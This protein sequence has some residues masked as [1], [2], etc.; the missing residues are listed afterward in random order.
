MRNFDNFLI[1]ENE[2]VIYLHGQF[3]FTN[4]H[5]SNLIEH[6]KSLDTDI[7]SPLIRNKKKLVY[8][9]GYFSENDIY[10]LDQRILKMEELVP[11]SCL[12]Y[13]RQTQ[14]HYQQLF[15]CRKIFYQQ[16]FDNFKIS[17]KHLPQ[18]RIHATPFIQVCTF[19]NHSQQMIINP[20]TFENRYWSSSLQKHH[21]LLQ[22]YKIENYRTIN[23]NQLPNVLLLIEEEQLDL[24]KTKISYFQ[25]VKANFF[26]F[27]NQPYQALQPNRNDSKLPSDF[28]V[29]QYLLLNRDIKTLPKKHYLRHGRNE[30][31]EY[32]LPN[33]F[34]WKLYIF[35]NKDLEIIRKR[36]QSEEHYLKFGNYDFR[37]YKK[38]ITGG[39]LLKK[40]NSIDCLRY[41]GIHVNSQMINLRE[42]LIRNNNLFDY[43]LIL[44]KDYYNHHLDMISKISSR[45][46]ISWIGDSYHLVDSYSR[47]T[48]YPLV[49]LPKSD[50]K[51]TQICLIYQCYYQ[52]NNYQK[53]L[54]YFRSLNNNYSY[55]LILVNNNPDLHYVSPKDPLSLSITYLESDNQ[56]QEMGAYQTALDYIKD[57]H[58][59][60]KFS[61]YILL[62]ETLFTNFP[63]YT[64][65]V[66]NYNHI[67]TAVMEPI[68]IGK[69][70]KHRR[71]D[72]SVFTCNG[73]IFGKWIRSNFLLI[74]SNVFIKMLHLKLVRYTPENIFKDDEI[75]IPMSN[76]LKTK[77]TKWLSRKRYQHYNLEKYKLK[78]SSILNE[79]NLSHNLRSLSKLIHL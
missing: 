11:D 5:K 62:N 39:F 77:I 60:S 76:E 18:I 23:W 52:I 3:V 21:R 54:N 50:S 36:H 8:F 30:Q 66:L 13:C 73:C 57:N 47:L 25:K 27:G 40:L 43:I 4:E 38:N 58:L 14:H 35:I 34:N 26:V 17:I 53:V 10:Y 32:K 7:L 51:N 56:Y 63:L 59:V 15:I 20:Y 45:S 2:C 67:N 6:F 37:S 55:H 71:K 22:S 74:N 9:G 69:I 28:D 42:M 64:V 70:D 33:D 68:I 61:A 75:N 31:R 72:N 49:I 48:D 29:K 65:D 46:K 19:N 41:H 44:G 12:F 1:Y 24:I 16:H 79:Y 78:V